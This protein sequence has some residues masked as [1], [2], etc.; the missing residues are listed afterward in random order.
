MFSTLADALP[1]ANSGAIRLLA[2]SGDKRAAQVPDVPTVSEAGYAGYKVVT[3]NGLMAP[4][5]TAKSII[6]RT[7]A[8]V[9]R[10]VKD[11]G[12]AE[13]LTKFGVDPLGNN[14]AEFARLIAAELPLWAD[15]VKIAGVKSQ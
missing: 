3:W 8:E 2:V 6:D 1:H 9:A 11:K 13:R 10:A 15:A 4:A 12:F 5:Q 7:A 14:P